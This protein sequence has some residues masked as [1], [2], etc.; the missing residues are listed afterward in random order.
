M[1]TNWV[2]YVARVRTGGKPPVWFVVALAVA[3][4]LVAAISIVLFH[5]RAE[6]ARRSE[7]LV[8]RIAEA[9][10]VE[11][12]LL[13]Q[14]VA[15]GGIDQALDGEFRAIDA[16]LALLFGELTEVNRTAA[17][18]LSKEYDAYA[19]TY[20]ARYLG[21]IRA[22]R[23][24][25]ALSAIEAD[26]VYFNSFS[27]LADETEQSV[28]SRANR[29]AD[30]AV[31]GRVAFLALFLSVLGFSGIY[32]HQ[33]QV[34]VRNAEALERSESRIRAL[35]DATPDTMY[36][37]SE[38]GT[39]RDYKVPEGSASCGDPT[40]FIG[41]SLREVMPTMGADCVVSAIGNTLQTGMMQ[42]REYQIQGVDS[43][44]EFEAR[45]VVSGPS[46]VVVLVR[47]VTDR[48]EVENALARERDLL[49][50]LMSYVPDPI[51]FKDL[52]G[53]YLR[54]NRADSILM[55]LAHPDEA[56]GKTDEDLTSPEVASARM[57][58]DQRIMKERAPVVDRIESIMGANGELRWFSTTKGPTFDAEGNV[59]GVVGVSRDV[60]E[61]KLLEEKLA[62]HALHDAL[63]GLPNRMLFSTQIEHAFLLSA[64]THDPLAVLFVDLDEF[65]VVNDS[66]GHACGDRL[67][68]VIAERLRLCARAGDTVARIGGDEF[69]VL[70][71][72]SNVQQA[73][74][75]A[76]RIQRRLADPV[77]L[78]GHSVMI[79]ASIGIA[80]T[81][82]SLAN[83]EEL[84][85]GADL[86]MYE[87]KQLGRPQ[88]ATYSQD[89]QTRVIEPR[90]LAPELHRA[91]A[92][93]E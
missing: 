87:A 3:V 77:D 90:K 63:T 14:S 40:D 24:I 41:R 66:F 17:A 74:N 47:D 43:T 49:H 39:I 83:A 88:Y 9:V 8:H 69:I 22:G 38:D 73:A 30:Q 1:K 91:I 68:V 16:Q 78:F 45:L 11:H 7:V 50:L 46:E 48:K 92:G 25:D 75:A 19:E 6:S 84:L 70:L 4:V 34:R 13:Y 28:G 42:C 26:Q 54:I 86:A 81:S 12:E 44:R 20:V 27:E 57:A 64:R 65:K 82:S 60:T 51:F 89:I 58:D 32:G 15:K 2:R 85:R 79:S 37:L 76:R 52:S 80:A 31:A 93:E 59:S 71:E 10:D 56:V 72:N 55:G 53:R 62:H 61:R 35:L 21:L 33:A 18:T 67:L 5:R 23:T 29:L 36:R